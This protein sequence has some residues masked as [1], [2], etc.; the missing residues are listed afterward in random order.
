M[1]WSIAL[2]LTFPET[3]TLVKI[4]EMRA[5]MLGCVSDSTALRGQCFI[6]WR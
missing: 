6:S 1:L 4:W 5:G 3:A 2:N